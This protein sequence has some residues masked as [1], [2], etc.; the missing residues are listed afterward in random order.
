MI[1]LM[2]KY[3]FVIATDSNKHFIQDLYKKV[4]SKILYL[5]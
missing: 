3:L 2:N 4:V 5:F 1:I